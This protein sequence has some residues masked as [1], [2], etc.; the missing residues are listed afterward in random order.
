MLGGHEWGEKCFGHCKQS[1]AC[2]LLCGIGPTTAHAQ[3][4][5]SK[6]VVAITAGCNTCCTAISHGEV[7]CGVSQNARAA[8]GKHLFARLI[9]DSQHGIGELSAERSHVDLLVELAGIEND[10]MRHGLQPSSNFVTLR[11][12]GHSRRNVLTVLWCDFKHRIEL[13]RA[14]SAEVRC[15]DVHTTVVATPAQCT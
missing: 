9:F 3:V 2:E 6:C 15:D 12:A 11:L 8:C 10:E 14:R 1:L 13:A 4:Q 7:R 5:I